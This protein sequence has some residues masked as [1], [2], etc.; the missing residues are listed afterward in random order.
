MR[1]SDHGKQTYTWRFECCNHLWLLQCRNF[2][3]C[4]PHPACGSQQQN[5]WLMAT[6][7][8]LVLFW[9]TTLNQLWP[10]QTPNLVILRNWAFPF[11]VI[12]IGLCLHQKEIP[13]VISDVPIIGEDHHDSTNWNARSS[14]CWGN[15][16]WHNIQGRNYLLNCLMRLSNLKPRTKQTS[17]SGI[18]NFYTVTLYFS[19][20]CII[21]SVQW[22]GRVMNSFELMHNS[23]HSISTSV[24]NFNDNLEDINWIKSKVQRWNIFGLNLQTLYVKP[25]SSNQ[26]T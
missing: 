4:M 19:R 21:W 11:Q 1:A 24:S 26:N 5:G 10:N 3:V 20:E 23:G 15:W 18:L 17:Q 22:I 9:S 13:V 16:T 12:G 14:F 25:N 6:T 8:V 2:Y 7:P